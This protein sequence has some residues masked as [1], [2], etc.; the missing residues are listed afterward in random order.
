[1]VVLVVLGGVVGRRGRGFRG[2]CA[3]DRLP[4]P[5]RPVPSPV[6]C[7]DVVACRAS[8]PEGLS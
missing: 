2:P 1:M 6:E 3:L 8:L 7:P 5:D 4:V